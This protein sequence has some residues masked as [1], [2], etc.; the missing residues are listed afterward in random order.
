MWLLLSVIFIVLLV[1]YFFV[2]VKTEEEKSEG[3][4]KL[5][6]WLC[7]VIFIL[8][9]IIAMVLDQIPFTKKAPLIPFFLRIVN[10][11]VED[12][13]KHPIFINAFNVLFSTLEL[14]LL[15]IT[16]FQLVELFF[17]YLEAKKVTKLVRFVQTELST[18]CSKA[19]KEV[20]KE[21]NKYIFVWKPNKTLARK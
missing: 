20:L 11:R 3:M 10:F 19:L 8:L 15:V 9:C 21:L 2:A 7:A 1:A 12:S 14:Q 13:L 4:Q 17:R 6:C 16:F 18:R 5:G